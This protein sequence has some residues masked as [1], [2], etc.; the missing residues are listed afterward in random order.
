M[1]FKA[2]TD[3]ERIFDTIN[4]YSFG[5]INRD[6]INKQL[7]SLDLNVPDITEENEEEEELEFGRPKRDRS[8]ELEYIKNK[9]AQNFEKTEKTEVKKSR[10]RRHVDNSEAK[11]LMKE[12]HNKTHFKAATDITLFNRMN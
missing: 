9:I 8:E 2:R 11:N 3:L 5:R 4:S 1:R 12:Y 10:K 7:K 6:I